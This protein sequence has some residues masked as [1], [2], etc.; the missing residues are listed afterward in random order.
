ME[1]TLAIARD[2]S[3]GMLFDH[4]EVERTLGRGAMG[5]VYLARDLRIGRKVALKAMP[6]TRSFDSADAEQEFLNRFRREAELCGSLAH[7]NI[8]TLFEVGWEG[9]RISFLAMEYVDGETLLSLLH[10]EK[11]LDLAPSLKIVDDI[12]HGLAYAHERH[13]VHRDVKPANILITRQGQAK[14]ADFGV[15]RYARTAARSRTL[16]NGG[17]LIGTPYYMSPE[18]IAGRAAEPSSDLFSVGVVLFE[19]LSGTRPFDGNDLLDVLYNIV[20]APT[21]DL[22]RLRPDLPPWVGAFVRRLLAKAPGDRF[23][24]A[25]AAIRE[26]RRNLGQAAETNP[27]LVLQGMSTPSLAPEET[28]TTPITAPDFRRRRRFEVRRTVPTSIG[29]AIIVAASALLL[30]AVAFIQSELAESQPAAVEALT[31]QEIATREA[32][33]REARVLYDARMYDASAA[34]Y[35]AYLENYPWSDAAR[36]GEMMAL[37]ALAKQ[38][39]EESARAQRQREELVRKRPARSTPQI[40]TTEPPV[41]VDTV[42]PAPET[43][44]EPKPS[45]WRRIFRRPDP[46]PGS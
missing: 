28:P 17:Q 39:E 19:L 30:G 15:A 25:D 22:I 6:K 27:L 43:K 38:K 9:R 29:I 20:N 26:L 42:Q 3:V 40:A 8:I 34:R 36:E 44:P 33:L 5:V 1:E 7:P 31:P 11:K 21:P 13:V 16:T 12:L 23:P 10:R 35:R 41:S 18:L 14:I 32:L 37:E 45:I 46:P 24:S 4:Y 2:E